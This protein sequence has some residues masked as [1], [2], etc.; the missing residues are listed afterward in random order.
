VAGPFVVVGVNTN[1]PMLIGNTLI[2]DTLAV[3]LW[4]ETGSGGPVNVDD[5]K[6]NFL[7]SGFIPPN[8]NC[9]IDVAYNP[10][11]IDW[12]NGYSIDQ[13][14]QAD[15]LTLRRTQNVETYNPTTAISSI[16]PDRQSVAIRLTAEQLRQLFP[17]CGT[18]V[19]VSGQSIPVNDNLPAGLY[20]M[21]KD[22]AVIRLIIV[23]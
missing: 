4:D 14:G 21:N 6:V 16:S 23:E 20:F 10:G 12:W 9:R 17:G 19:N 15:T 22:R 5:N 1:K 3:E 13:L 7:T 11:Y 8:T 18:I 2:A